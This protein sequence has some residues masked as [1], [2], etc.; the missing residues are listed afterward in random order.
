LISIVLSDI[1]MSGWVKTEDKCYHVRFMLV[2]NILICTYD[3]C[4]LD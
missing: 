1:L 3:I 4:L 2:M